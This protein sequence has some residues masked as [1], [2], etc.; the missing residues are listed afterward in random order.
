[1]EEEKHMK[2][3]K[4]LE[5]S[6]FPVLE[7][8]TCRAVKGCQHSC[9]DI[10][11]LA[12][13]IEKRLDELH[14]SEK[15]KARVQGPLR[16]HNVLKISLSGCPNCCSQPQIKDIGLRGIIGVKIDEDL[17]TSCGAC[18]EVCRENAISLNEK[19]ASI[20]YEKCIECGACKKVCAVQAINQIKQG[21][22]LLV[23]GKLG[24][25]PRLAT[26]EYYSNSDEELIREIE[27]YINILLEHGQ[28][29]ERLG[30]IIESQSNA[31]KVIS[32]ERKGS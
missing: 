27:K 6:N 16:K 3:L 26:H 23:G 12:K 28:C 24:R 5:L 2:H 11:S 14:I 32:F 13:F 8:N 21:C 30:D 29:H 20:N 1:M 25:H 15:L 18:T 22:D 4:D 9:Y 10:G 17:C 31:S 7:I 19:G